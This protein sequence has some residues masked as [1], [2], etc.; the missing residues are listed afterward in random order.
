MSVG[1]DGEYDENGVGYCDDADDD[2]DD[3]ADGECD[4]AR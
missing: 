1:D 3:D 2:V 4:G